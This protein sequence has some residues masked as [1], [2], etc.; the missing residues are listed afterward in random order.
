MPYKLWGFS[1]FLVGLQTISSPCESWNCALFSIHVVLLPTSCN[2][3]PCI[4]RW[5]FNLD[6]RS[7]CSSLL[8][9][10]IPCK[11]QSSWPSHTANFIS[12]T[13][14]HCQVPPRVHPSSCSSWRLLSG[15]EQGQSQCSPWLFPLCKV[16]ILY[17]LMS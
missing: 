15:S 11:L 16:T 3:L 6:C 4:N 12:S 1:L 2:F 7:L 17:C 5:L 13:Q 9:G 14:G 10:I 8:F